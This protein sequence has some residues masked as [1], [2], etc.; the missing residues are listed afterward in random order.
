MLKLRVYKRNM[1]FTKSIYLKIW[2][3]ETYLG[4]IV[5]DFYLSGSSCNAKNLEILIIN[6]K[7][8]QYA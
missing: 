4:N 8:H 3:K 7:L 1:Y 6:S 5:Y 2:Q